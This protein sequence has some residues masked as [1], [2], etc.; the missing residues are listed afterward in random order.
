MKG[1]CFGLLAVLLFGT[2]G[3]WGNPLPAVM[4]VEFSTDPPWIE[5][6][7]H[8]QWYLG[9]AV[10]YTAD[11]SI[12]IN[13]GVVIGYDELLILDESNTSGICLDPVGDHMF[14]GDSGM[15]QWFGYG[16]LGP[17]AAPPIESS[18]G[19]A[20]VAPWFENYD[21]SIPREPTPGEPNEYLLIDR[22]NTDVVISE[23][24]FNSTWPNGNFV[25]LHNTADSKIDLSDWRIVGNHSYTVPAG[26]L[27][28]AHDHFALRESDYP[29]FF[30]DLSQPD[31]IYLLN[32][33]NILVDQVGWSSGHPE[34]V[35]FM[36]YPD[37]DAHHFDGYDDQTSADFEEGFPTCREFN[38]YDSPGFVIIGCEASQAGGEVRILWTD[39]VWD[40]D[41]ETSALVKKTD[42]FSNHP[43]DGQL[44][45]EG[46]QEFF[47]DSEVTS[48]DTYYYTV[49]AFDVVGN[50]SE[51]QDCSRDSITVWQQLVPEPFPVELPGRFALRQNYPN[52]FNSQTIIDYE[53]PT[54]CRVKLEVF[55][56]LGEKV[57]ILVEGMQNAGQESVVWDASGVSSGVY[58]YRLTAGD[59]R[60]SRRLLLVK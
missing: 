56:L 23:V 15:S 34:D 33:D 43:D 19:L 53:L 2:V 27:V 44:I 45:Y 46:N 30:S 54:A 58:L 42:G 6:H 18:S 5:L 31:N 36:R 17:D 52:P 60:H 55:N 16:F 1:F 51:P 3:V 32:G 4:I 39:P 57:E 28:K 11:D 25:E 29:E 10:I 9:G 50:H 40:E 47:F 37:W 49:F 7:G 8:D 26:T 12:L 48:G 14:A 59:F 21:F 20:E 22:G 38:R 24:N 13:D 41:Y 35:S